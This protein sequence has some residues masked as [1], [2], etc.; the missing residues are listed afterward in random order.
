M[1]AVTEYFPVTTD[2]ELKGEVAFGYFQQDNLASFFLIIK[3]ET[4]LYDSLFDTYDEINTARMTLFE[5]NPETMG[6]FPT[7]GPVEGLGDLY[8]GM[9]LGNGQ[10]LFIHGDSQFTEPFNF[11]NLQWGESPDYVPMVVSFSPDVMQDYETGETGDLADALQYG[12]YVVTLAY[13][14]NQ[15]DIYMPPIKYKTLRNLWASLKEFQAEE[16]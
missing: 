4:D 9:S 1:G 7:Y 2:A 14:D 12:I 3:P 8:I 5:K 6:L 10:N 13:R 15:W 11:V 16:Q